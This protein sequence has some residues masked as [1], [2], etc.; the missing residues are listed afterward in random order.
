MCQG[1]KQR[2]TVNT[3][4]SLSTVALVNVTTTPKLAV[5]LKNRTGS[6][7]IRGCPEETINTKA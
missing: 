1:I 2:R 6:A 3:H 4:F 7:V 5:A